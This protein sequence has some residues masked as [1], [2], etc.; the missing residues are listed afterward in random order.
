MECKTGVSSKRKVEIERRV[1][2][3]ERQRKNSISDENEN[4]NGGQ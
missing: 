4:V 2:G 3:E 1:N